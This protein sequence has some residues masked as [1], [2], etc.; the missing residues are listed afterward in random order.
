MKNYMVYYTGI[1]LLLFLTSQYVV[2]EATNP[3]RIILDSAETESIF[4][5]EPFLQN[6]TEEGI[7]I[8]WFTNTKSHGWVEFGT[9]KELGERAIADI[10]G[11]A[12]AN[13]KHHKVRLENLHP[14]TKYFYRICSREVLQYDPYKKDFGEIE[15]S[16]T[17]SFILPEKDKEDFTALIFNDLHKKQRALKVLMDQVADIDYDFVFY[18]GDCLDDPMTQDEALDFISYSNQQVNAAEKPFFYLRGNHEIRGAFSVGLNKIIDYVGGQTFGAFNWGDTRFVMLDCG[19]DKP[20]DHWVYYGLNNF[21]KLRKDQKDFLEKERKNKDFVKASKR[22]LIHHI[23]IYG[24]R[25][26]SYSPCTKLWSDELNQ[27]KI[28]LALNGHT[29]RFA[30][31]KANKEKHRYPIVIGGGYKNTDATVMVLSKKGDVLNLRVIAY[32]GQILLNENF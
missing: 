18:N 30:Y 20:D 9:T 11:Q 1:F 4:R 19:E 21:D 2:G 31:H 23:P 14:G 16:K 5:T 3:N 26:D 6:P 17:F 29:H 12:V 7:T 8:S 28:S 25:K 13:V 27:S 22:V 32:N 24:L 15:H 10:G